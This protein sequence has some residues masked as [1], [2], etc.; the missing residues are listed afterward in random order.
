MNTQIQAL[1]KQIEEVCL[2]SNMHRAFVLKALLTS[3]ESIG[4]LPVDPLALPSIEP[5]YEYRGLRIE[6]NR[7]VAT[8]NETPLRFTLAEWK[9]LTALIKSDGRPISKNQLVSLV[10]DS[11]KPNSN[12]VE[13][14]LSHLRAKVG[15]GVI[16]TMRGIGYV[17]ASKVILKS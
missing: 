3:Y 12:T 1:S 7:M 14:F 4:N 9:I 16:N 10:Y 2:A 13:V 11:S 8:L 6:L 15:P 17:L 5:D